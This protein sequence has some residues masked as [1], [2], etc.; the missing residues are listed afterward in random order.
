MNWGN[1]IAIKCDIS[2]MMYV[3]WILNLILNG[4]YDNVVG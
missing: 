1:F 3:Y 4:K 2:L